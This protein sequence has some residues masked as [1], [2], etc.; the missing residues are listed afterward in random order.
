MRMQRWNCA[1]L[2][3]AMVG[4]PFAAT[5]QD[6][7][8]EADPVVAILNG[9][10]ILRSEVIESA[11]DLP[12]QYQAQV[13][14]IMPALIERL[15]DMKLLSLAASDAGLA[16]DEEVKS[17]IERQ[18]QEIIRQ[19]Y[20]TRL[21]EAKV[22]DDSIQDAYQVYLTENLPPTEVSARHIL[23]ENEADAQEIIVALEAGG[24]FAELA[25]ERST[26]PSAAQG[27][28][29]GYFTADQ[30]V[31]PF[32]EA[33]FALEPGQHS[34]APVETQ[35]GWHVIKVEDRRTGEPPAFED[36]EEE[37]RSSLAREAVNE[38]VLE[39]RSNADIELIE[40]EAEAPQAGG[41]SQ[42]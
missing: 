30:M 12:A 28:D 26:G 38:T 10:S 22:T 23:L 18:R 5:A 37:L 42:Q 11:R 19:V 8:S 40:G 24:D 27:G 3:L 34:K 13:Q 1:L 32:S 14:L 29:L 9:E 25:R 21:V 16:D 4:L 41:D 6:G 35:F 20:V 33:A 17:L 31:E 15:I 36:V 39:L 2:G 7:G